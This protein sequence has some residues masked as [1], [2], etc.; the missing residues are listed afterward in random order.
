MIYQ[1]KTNEQYIVKVPDTIEAAMKLMEVGL[2]CHAEIEGHKL[3][4]KKQ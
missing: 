1:T 2:E 3:F 4:R